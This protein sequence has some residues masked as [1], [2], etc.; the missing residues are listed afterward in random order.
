MCLGWRES[1]KRPLDIAFSNPRTRTY[2]KSPVLSV[3]LVIK[4]SPFESGIMRLVD[5]NAH[6]DGRRTL[7]ISKLVGKII[8]KID[9]LGLC[10]KGYPPQSPQLVPA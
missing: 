10:T 4:P 1:F 6:S 2:L 8:N 3:N 5:G 7:S 9:E